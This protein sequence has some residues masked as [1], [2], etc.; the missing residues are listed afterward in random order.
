MTITIHIICLVTIANIQ[1]KMAK[2]YKH[3]LQLIKLKPNVTTTNKKEFKMTDDLEL[4][5]FNQ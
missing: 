5:D 4:L 1:W 2:I 3:V